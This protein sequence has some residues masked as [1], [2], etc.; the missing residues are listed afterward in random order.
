MPYITTGL[1][2][3]PGYGLVS[4]GIQEKDSSLTKK[5]AVEL[6]ECIQAFI[7][8]DQD[9]SYLE[10]ENRKLKAENEFMLRLINEWKVKELG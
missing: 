9:R 8:A 1:K 6:N 3:Y 10:E 7:H 4:K 2:Y 5:I